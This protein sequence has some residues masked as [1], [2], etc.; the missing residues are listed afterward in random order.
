M[1]TLKKIFHWFFKPK[2]Q[3]Q[4]IH[5]S[6]SF[7]STSALKNRPSTEEQLVFYRM[8]VRPN[9]IFELVCISQPNAK[10]G[11]RVV[12]CRE[13]TSGREAKVDEDMFNFNFEKIDSPT[14]DYKNLFLQKQ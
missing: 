8:R 6:V 3:E 11:M 9:F 12:T 4:S 5:Y 2:K 7:D 10:T 13:V 1:K 14:L